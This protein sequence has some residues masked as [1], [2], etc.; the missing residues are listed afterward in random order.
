MD[1]ITC[2][3]LYRFIGTFNLPVSLKLPEY[4]AKYYAVFPGSSW[5]LHIRHIILTVTGGS[6]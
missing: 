1:C 3:L 5:Y 6:H 2:D 4:N